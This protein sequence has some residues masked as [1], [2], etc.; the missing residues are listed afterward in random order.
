MKTADS[1]NGSLSPIIKEFSGADSNTFMETR[2]S[3]VDREVARLRPQIDLL[4]PENGIRRLEPL[5]SQLSRQEKK[6]RSLNVDHRLNLMDDF[7]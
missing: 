6:I 7:R 4:Q 2:L 5:E 3:V 1:L